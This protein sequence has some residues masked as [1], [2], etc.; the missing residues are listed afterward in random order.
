MSGAET[1]TATVEEFIRYSGARTSKHDAKAALSR[2]SGRVTELEQ[3]AK[4]QA[5]NHEYVVEM[6][7]ALSSGVGLA[8][9]AFID[10]RPEDARRY[11]DEAV[12]KCPDF[13]EYMERYDA[14]RALAGSAGQEQA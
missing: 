8:R 2:L 7:G 11:L 13:G 9:L 10:G 12:E 6:H 14:A 3:E 1:D 4:L 5:I